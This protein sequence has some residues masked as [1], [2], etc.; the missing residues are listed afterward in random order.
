[1]ANG[2]PHGVGET[3]EIVG[4]GAQGP[5]RWQPVAGPEALGLTL[6]LESQDTIIQEAVNVLQRCIPPNAQVGHETGLVVGYVQSGKTMSFTTVT[7]LARDNGYQMV[8]V[9]AGT[10]L[11]LFGQSKQRLIRDLRLE[12]RAERSPWRHIESPTLAGHADVVIRDS[13][14]EWRDQRVPAEERKTVLVTVMKQHQNLEK[15]VDVL[16]QLPPR[17]SSNPRD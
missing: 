15:L 16:R 5:G 8:I 11:Y 1:M 3:V 9:I 10:S 17:R 13:L 2:V 7:A 4:D 12:N 14:A 6:P